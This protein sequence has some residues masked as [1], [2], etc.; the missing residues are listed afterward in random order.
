MAQLGVGPARV[1]GASATKLGRPAQRAVTSWLSDRAAL[2][3]DGGTAPA[4]GR[5]RG[6]AAH[7][8]GD[9]GAA[10]RRRASGERGGRGGPGDGAVGEAVRATAARATQSGGGRRTRGGREV[11][12]ASEASCR[13]ARRAVP[14]AALSHGVGEAHGSHVATARCR[15]GPARHAASDRWAPFISDF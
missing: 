1:R 6:T 10:R 11:G 14:T 12:G 13:D 3:A 5:R 9:S 2:Q 7:R 4:H 8:R 15:A